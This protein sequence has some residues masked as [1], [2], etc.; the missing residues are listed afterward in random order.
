MPTPSE[1]EPKTLVQ[2]AAERGWPPLRQT[3]QFLRLDGASPYLVGPRIAAG[4][5]GTIH[6]GLKQGALGFQRLLAIKRLHSHLALEPDFVARFKDEIHLVSRLT[7]PNVVQTFDVVDSAGEV[8]LVMEFVDGVTLQD[9]LKDA[10]QADTFLPVPVAV[11]IVIQ[12]LH[13]LHAAHE[14]SGDDGQQLQ[15]V[16]RDISP[17]NIMIAKDGLVKVLDFGIAKAAGELHVTRT[18]QL[19]GKASYMSPEQVSGRAVDRRTDV[20]AAGVVLWESLTGQRLFRAP[21]M[22][23]AAALKNVLDMRVRS[24]GEIREGVSPA[25]ERIVLRALERDITRRYGSARDMA[26]ALEE[27]VPEAS[28]SAIAGGVAE[29]CRARLAAGAALLSSFRAGVAREPG[30]SARSPSAPV[31]SSP[32]GLAPEPAAVSSEG[33]TAISIPAPPVSELLTSDLS[34]VPMVDSPRRGAR[35]RFVVGL[36]AAGCVA[37]VGIHFARDFSR[38]NVGTT[39]ATV[40]PKSPRPLESSTPPSLDERPAPASELKVTI[41]EPAPRE[42]TGTAPLA[43]EDPTP[44]EALPRVVE[45]ALA[46]DSKDPA[47]TDSSP[48]KRTQSKRKVSRSAS[49]PATDEPLPSAALSATVQRQPASMRT[50]TGESSV[51]NCSPPTYTDAEGIR[52]FKVECL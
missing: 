26:L 18:G 51:K 44:I 3:T 9:L 10:V 22:V 32:A 12:A 36:L 38:P 27:A 7:H 19:S 49:S 23:E 15:L 6:V 4:G 48:T 14:V 46:S 25:L 39:V 50:P 45:L 47:A 2:S 24:P 33:H 17:Q 52:H 11:G 40:L 43:S 30:R 16:H 13:G 35:W 5:M 31:H 34:G 42:A 1:Q 20:F 37:A 28:P 29:L 21:G 8:A 41:G